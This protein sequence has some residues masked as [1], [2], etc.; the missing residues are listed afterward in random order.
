M[1][2]TVNVT[3]SNPSDKDRNNE[4]IEIKASE[5]L[6]GSSAGFLYVTDND[7]KEIPSQIT[8]DSLFIFSASVPAAGHATY[9]IHTSETPHAYLPVATGKT[10]PER[11]DDLSW[12]NDLVGFRAYG[13]ATRRKGEKAFGYDIF[14]KH[15][16][17]TPVL[18][19]LY[20]MQTSSAN[21]MK[22]DSLK[23]I[24]PRKAGAFQRLISYH[25]DSG[26]GM[27]CYAVGP[28]LGDGTAAILCR[29]SIYYPWTY[30]NIE[31]LD[32]GPLR[33]TAR[34]I[35]PKTSIEKDKSV[36]ESRIITLDAGTHLNKCTVC[37]DGLSTP[38]EIVTGFPLRDDS[39]TIMDLPN[40][41]IAYADPTQGPDN[42]KALLGVILPDGIKKSLKKDNHILGVSDTSTAKPFTYYWGFAWNKADIQSLQAWHEYLSEI[43]TRQPLSYQISTSL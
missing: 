22:V 30:E 38:Q 27:D 40:G 36:V 25:I 6:K 1:A 20:D 21:W 23:K 9:Q 11:Q 12:E 34:L 28:T 13:P 17:Q 18:D 5:L 4:I 10:R 16:T 39:E 37:F 8:H 24:D 31:I 42:G 35:F 33:F 19:I 32:N 29:D 15:P 43:A 7:M 14:F 26:L 3:V 41:I 2:K